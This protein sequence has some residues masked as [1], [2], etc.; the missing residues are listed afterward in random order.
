MK[1]DGLTIQLDSTMSA[2]CV[3]ERLFH[4]YSE[5]INI[6]RVLY[7]NL[8]LLLKAISTVLQLRELSIKESGISK[9]VTA[10]NSE[11]KTVVYWI[12][13]LFLYKLN[14]S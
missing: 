4:L 3:E 13:T 2:S 14:L 11:R 7:V 6:D 1:G 10:G 12:T 5:T 8:S 9:R